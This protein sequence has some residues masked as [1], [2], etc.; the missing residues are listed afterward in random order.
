MPLDQF[1]RSDYSG[2]PLSELLEVRLLLGT[3]DLFLGF[4]FVYN[5]HIILTTNLVLLCRWGGREKQLAEQ[6][7]KGGAAA[8]AGA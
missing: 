8:E 6:A 1:R 3:P 5:H 2:I 7:A 4:V